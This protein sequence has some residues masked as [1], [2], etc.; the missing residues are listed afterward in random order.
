MSKKR[1]IILIIL[2]IL[3]FILIVLNI[4]FNCNND[5][6][7]SDVESTISLSS[8]QEKYNARMK[9]VDQKLLLESEH[10]EKDENKKQVYNFDNTYLV[11]T[12]DDNKNIEK[13]YFHLSKE[14]YNKEEW[15]EKLQILVKSM[16]ENL[17]QQDIEKIVQKMQDVDEKKADEL[18]LI[19]QFEDQNREYLTMEKENGTII[20][21]FIYV[22]KEN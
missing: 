19:V 15:E 17:S 22:E 20:E 5:K 1:K 3:I 7:M 18:G 14:T 2:A 21:F 8:F 11:I 10:L 9:Q 16:N 13:V 6:N 12:Y 4:I